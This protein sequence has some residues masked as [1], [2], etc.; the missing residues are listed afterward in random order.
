MIADVIGVTGWTYPQIGEMTMPQLQL[1]LRKRGRILW[2]RVEPMQRYAFSK[3]S[4]EPVK[5]GQPSPIQEIIQAH[6]LAR[7]LAQKGL[8][9]LPSD[10]ERERA[11]AYRI[12]NA[13]YLGDPDAPQDATLAPEA[14]PIPGMAA[15]TARGLLGAAR[16]GLLPDDVWAEDLAPLLHRL[17]ATALRD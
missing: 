17:N 5:E 2:P 16:D 1:T 6:T 10:K 7:Q 8:K 9:P 4:S 11:H 13:A 15:A 3:I 12:V 14:E